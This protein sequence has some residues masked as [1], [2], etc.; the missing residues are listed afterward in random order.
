MAGTDLVRLHLDAQGHILSLQ[1]AGVSAATRRGGDTKLRG[2]V[3]LYRIG[4]A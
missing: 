1:R 4:K 3:I 2:R